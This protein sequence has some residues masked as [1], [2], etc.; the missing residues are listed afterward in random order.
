MPQN[1]LLTAWRTYRKLA[2]IDFAW[3]SA[4]RG[5]RRTKFKSDAAN[6]QND[7]KAM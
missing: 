7:S 1:G 4:L 3:V 5:V 2:V 6:R